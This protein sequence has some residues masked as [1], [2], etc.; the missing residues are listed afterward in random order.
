MLRHNNGG[1]MGLDDDY[2]STSVVQGSHR[3]FQGLD[4]RAIT[5]QTKEIL[6]Y[7]E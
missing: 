3:S 7:A 4:W 1:P 6:G 5:F 2:G